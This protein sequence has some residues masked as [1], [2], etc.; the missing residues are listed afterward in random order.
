MAG[1]VERLEFLQSVNPGGTF[2]VS[3][4][5]FHLLDEVRATFINAEFTATLMLTAAFVEHWL[6]ALLISRGHEKE[7]GAGLNSIVECMRLHSIGHSFVLEKIDRLRKIRIPFSHPK[8]MGYELGLDRRSLSENAAPIAV[9]EKEAKD[10]VSILYSVV[11]AF[12]EI[13]N[14]KTGPGG[15]SGLADRPA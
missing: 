7:I 5:M 13:S 11:T 10:A 8:G 4:E 9:L 3:Q 6:A 15:W 14:R 2:M 1:R 12:P